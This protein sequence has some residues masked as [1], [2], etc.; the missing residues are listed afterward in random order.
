MISG[1][2]IRQGPISGA[3]LID[4]APTVAR[5]LAV[6]IGDVDGAPLAIGP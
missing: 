2:G 4:I 6:D 1:P 3:R 5:W